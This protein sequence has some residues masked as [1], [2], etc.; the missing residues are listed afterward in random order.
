MTEIP[1]KTPRPIGRTA[2]FLPGIADSAAAAIPDTPSGVE[3]VRVPGGGVVLVGIPS[4]GVEVV[5]VSGILS[6]GVEVVPGGGIV[7]VV[8]MLSVVDENDPP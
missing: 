2:N 5:G 3:D 7:L 4:G 6:G 8:G 1:A